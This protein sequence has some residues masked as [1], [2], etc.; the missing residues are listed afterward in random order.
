M[1][2]KNYNKYILILG[3]LLMPIFAFAQRTPINNGF[4]QSNLNGNQKSGTNFLN[5]TTTQ[6]DYSTNALSNPGVATP[7]FSKSYI[8]VSTNA[9]FTFGLPVNINANINQT[10]VMIVTNA[11]KGSLMAI[12]APANVTP[13]GTWNCTNN[14]KTIVTFFQYGNWMTNATAL[15]LH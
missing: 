4:L 6:T 10:T 8:L 12:T 5:I 13:Q 15:P 9:D 2:N 14:G 3:L 11:N 7:D 1:K